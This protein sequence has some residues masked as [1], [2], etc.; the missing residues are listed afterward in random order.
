MFHVWITSKTNLCCASIDTSYWLLLEFVTLPP[1]KPNLIQDPI[2][3]SI[4]T[5]LALTTNGIAIIKALSHCQAETGTGAKACMGTCWSFAL[6]A[7]NLEAG[8]SHAN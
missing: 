8:K 2:P 7:V 5:K 6:V 4:C 3:H 1:T